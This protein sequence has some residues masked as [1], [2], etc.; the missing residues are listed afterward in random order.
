MIETGLSLVL[1]GLLI[2]VVFACGAA[3]ERLKVGDT[4][5]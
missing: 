5:E 2:S 3:G 1:L 4:N